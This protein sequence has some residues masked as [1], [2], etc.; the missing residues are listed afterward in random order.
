M[1]FNEVPEDEEVP[2]HPFEPLTAKLLKTRTILISGTVDE[3]LAER[4]ITELLILDGDSQ[5]PIRMFITSP[6]GHVDAGLAIHDV[7]RFIKPEIVAIGAGWVA[8][9]AVPILFGAPKENRLALPHTRFLLHQPSGGAAGHLKD[10]RIEAQEIMKIRKRL[11]EMIA[12][13]T[14]QPY[15]KVYEDSDRNFWMSAEEAIE[16]GV[17]S[18]VVESVDDIGKK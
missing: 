8:S 9:I 6:G 7:M 11:N 18:R 10:I 13:E 1:T 15:E 12:R 3:E 4:V 16:Y 17:I 5:E 14:G 2:K